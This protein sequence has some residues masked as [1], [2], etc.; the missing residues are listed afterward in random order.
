[1]NFNYVR[2]METDPVEQALLTRDIRNDIGFDL[3]MGVQYRPLLTDN[4]IVS[5][6]FGAL[7][8]GGGFK[9]IYRRN[10]DPVPGFGSPG[11]A[12][13]VDDFYY[14]GLFALTLTY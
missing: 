3:S 5:A 8:P 7:I 12:G 4:I 9:D 10:T 1:M 14:S 6:G 2:M 11:N 13:D